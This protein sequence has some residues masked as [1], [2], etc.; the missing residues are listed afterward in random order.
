MSVQ[1]ISNGNVAGTERRPIRVLLSSQH[2]MVREGIRRLLEAEADI[3]VIAETSG[4]EETVQTARDL[5]PDVLVF[6]LPSGHTR[7]NSVVRRLFSCLPVQ[8]FVILTDSDS[9]E[10][11]PRPSTPL[12][13]LSKSASLRDLIVAIRT[14]HRGESYGPVAP[15]VPNG[16][17][18]SAWSRD[19][20]TNRELD[21]LHLVSEGRSNREIA[22][23]LSIA[24]R[25]VEFHLSHAFEKL[26]ARSRTEA[27]HLARQRGWLE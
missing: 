26:G 12:G 27:V 23:T 14:V 2:T 10:A 22:L 5:Q 4:S 24:E 1:E 9:V 18:T 13:V 7:A 16:G 19:V 3:D 21:V 17:G 8:R 6:D 11:I 25:T 20:P 15:P